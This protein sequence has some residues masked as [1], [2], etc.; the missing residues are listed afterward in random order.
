MKYKHKLK[1][2]LFAIVATSTLVFLSLFVVTTHA[3]IADLTIDTECTDVPSYTGLLNLKDGEYTAYVRLAKRG[4]HQKVATYAQ[5]YDSY[6]N[7]NKLKTV[8][9]SGDT[10]TKVGTFH[11][12]GDTVIE[13]AADFLKYIPNANRP[14]VMLLPAKNPL[15]V[16]QIDCQVTVKGETGVVL[17]TSTLNNQNSLRVF[18]VHDPST[19]KISRVAY[20]VDNRIAYT[21][22]TLEPFDMRYVT[23]PGQELKRVVIYDS[24]QR[25]AIYSKV[26]E[27]YQDN[28]INFLFRT[29]QFNSNLFI[30]TV[31]LISLLIATSLLL[32]VMSAAKQRRE[33]R[34]RH[35]F[36][37]E[38]RYTITKKLYYTLL[39][40]KV[41]KVFRWLMIGLSTLMAIAATIFIVNMY[42][43]TMYTVDGVSMQSTYKTGDQLLIDKFSKTLASANNS[44]YVPKRGDVVIVHAVF[45]TADSLNQDVGNLYLVKRVIG[46]PGERIAIKNGV[47]TVYN[48]DNPKGFQPDAGASWQKTMTPDPKTES[49]DV[50]L[51]PSELFVC[52]DN[53]PESID[54]RF[55]GP[56]NTRELVGRVIL[57]L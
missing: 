41:Y 7:C 37:P 50:Q 32:S 8:T 26:S 24:G 1:I 15:C 33:W 46:L 9:A 51:G 13:L 6:G 40:T 12:N 30:G 2:T 14:A 56:V 47:L 36:I 28:F 34:M 39:N 10:W 17:P 27:T 45:G 19:D 49:I 11:A 44:E 35:G 42:V 4:E 16:P 43:L 22:K 54:S 57:K 25:I 31:I 5:Q 23:Y 55:N 20:Y 21:K 52:G 38:P 29:S 3:D 48:K 18:E 53:R